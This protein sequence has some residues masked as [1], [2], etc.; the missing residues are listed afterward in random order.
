MLR[1]TNAECCIWILG[2]NNKHNWYI[3]Y[4]SIWSGN[5]DRDR[6]LS[7]PIW[8][9]FCNI[10]D[11]VVL[12]EGSVCQLWTCSWWGALVFAD[13]L[14]GAEVTM[15]GTPTLRAA[16]HGTWS[17]AITVIFCH[18]EANPL[19]NTEEFASL[20]LKLSRLWKFW[21][22]RFTAYLSQRKAINQ[23]SSS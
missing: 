5:I 9:F 7:L 3:Y 14:P 16:G 23:I 8:C 17:L 19:Q 6:I 22:V 2:S 1:S 15:G 13:K 21:K 18:F 11:S 4:I 20:P 10:S 12:R